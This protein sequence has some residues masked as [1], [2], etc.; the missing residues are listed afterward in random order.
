MKNLFKTL[1]KPGRSPLVRPSCPPGERIYCIGDIHGR[2]DLLGQILGRILEH[3]SGYS[4][5]KTLVYLGDY[6]DR[7]DHSREVIDRL[8]GDPLPGFGQIHLR[9]NH[10]QSLLDFINQPRGG[11]DWLSYGG[12]Q[13]LASYGI[14]CGKIPTGIED[15]KALQQG[16]LDKLPDE[17]ARFYAETRFSFSRGS[18]YFVHAG[19]HPGLPLQDQQPEDQLWIRRKFIEHRKPFEKIIVHGHT[20][21][22]EVE[23]MDNRIGLDTGAYAT[24]KLS[25]LVLEDDTQALIQTH[26]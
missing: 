3:A 13:T 23:F 14:R 6:I 7:G 8:L 19:I 26:G 4:G 24:G 18:Y 16:L 21:S 22:E 12:L 20:I 25:C 1:F 17:H 9:G 10:E 5:T 11:F 15:L 2:D